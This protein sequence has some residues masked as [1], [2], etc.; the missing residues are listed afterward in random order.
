MRKALLALWIFLASVC[1]DPAQMMQDIVNARAPV[2]ATYV[3]PGDIVSGATA[4]YGLRGYN[5][6]YASPGTNLAVNLRRANDNATCDFVIATSGALGGTASACAQGGGLSLATFATQDATA[7]C[8]IATTIATCTSGSSV[9]HAGSTITGAGVTLPC[10]ASAAGSGT[11]PSFTVAIAGNGTTSPCGTIGA[12]VTLTFT[13]GLFVT[14]AYDQSGHTADASQ[15]T[16]AKQ[17]EL[18]PNCIS[19]LPCMEF[20]RTASQ[21][22]TTSGS[23]SSGA[24]TF[25]ISVVAERTQAFTSF[26][27]IFGGTSASVGA[28]FNN[29]ANT[30]MV[31]QGSFV[32]ATANDSVAHAMQFIANTTTSFVNVDGTPGS[33]GNANTTAFPATSNI[34][35]GAGNAF[36]GFDAETV[37]WSSVFSSGQ[38]TSMCNNQRLYYGTAASC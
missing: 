6:A 26:S 8:T 30:A 9:P 13:Y 4:A 32:T 24:A 15:A 11:A 28:F 21:G 38:N 29:S 33:T 34:G 18:L 23:P 37:I 36:G 22:L 3:G 14:T 19:A 25:T 7:T 1:P 35:I 17:P 12:G 16:A 10:Y 2:A 5:A 27:N 20:T 31:S